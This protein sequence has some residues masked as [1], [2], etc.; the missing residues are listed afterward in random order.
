MANAETYEQRQSTYGEEQEMDQHRSLGSLVKEIRDESIELFQ[1]EVELARTEMMEKFAVVK[2]R[3]VSIGIGAVIAF[4]GAI[5]LLM[6]IAQAISVVLVYAG[7]A[8]VVATWL[9]P[10]LTGLVVLLVGGAMVMSNKNKLEEETVVPEKT[11]Q[12]MKENKQWLK[13]K[14]T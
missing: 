4:A 7:M 2:D 8:A 11:V 14:T 12:S 1:Q 3:T 5:V 6:G 13:E 10:V 9:G